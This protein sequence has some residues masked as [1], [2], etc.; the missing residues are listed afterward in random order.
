MKISGS[1]FVALLALLA[2]TH[3]WDFELFEEDGCDGVSIDLLSG[4]G[5]K[6]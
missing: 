2:S 1:T 5:D 6:Q 4:T 3:A